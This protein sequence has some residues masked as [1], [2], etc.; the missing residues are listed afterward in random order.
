[1]NPVVS[2]LIPVYNTEST[3]ADCLDSIIN[4]TYKN[5]E[6][7]VV[8]D[9]TKDNAMDIVRQYASADERIKIFEHET[10]QGL[11]M[12]RK[13][14]YANATGDYIVFVDSDDTLPPESIERKLNFIIEHGCDFVTSGIS[15]IWPGTDK[16]I[17]KMPAAQGCFNLKNI[18]KMLLH[19]QLWHNLCSCIFP[20]E[21]LKG[22][23]Y[24]TYPGLTMGEDMLLFYQIADRCKKIGVMQQSLYNYIQYPGSATNSSYTQKSLSE[25]VLCWNVQYK[26]FHKNGFSDDCIYRFIIPEIVYLYYYTFAPR[27]YS[28]LCPELKAGLS[29]RNL[30]R[31]IS[32]KQSLT[33]LVL[34]KTKLLSRLLRY[35]FIRFRVG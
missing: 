6:I 11:M 33:F 30:F 27:I 29:T 5:L 2:V 15:F 8:N 16:S 32:I 26:F 23:K 24:T 4:Q 9:G 13:T 10:N 14:G 28:D 19:Y 22:Y 21:L 35:L 18:G 34:D 1:M 12:T 25:K 20:S 3:V 7:I 31:H 17:I